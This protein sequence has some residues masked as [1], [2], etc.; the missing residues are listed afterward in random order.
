MSSRV[1][2]WLLLGPVVVG[3]TAGYVGA[4]L[5]PTL[6][7][8]SPLLLI[9]LN[10]RNYHLALVAGEIAFAAFFVVAFLRLVTLD[11]LLFL[12]GR[13][14]GPSGRQ[15]IERQV[16]GSDRIVGWLDRWFPR[17]GWAIVFAAP[18]TVVCLLAGVT[19]MRPLVFAV[20]NVTGT[21]ARILAIW[22]L[23]QQFESQLDS[24]LDFFN[25][26]QTPATIVAVVLVM[27]Q[28][29]ISARRGGGEIGDVVE[30][31]R[32]LEQDL[33]ESGDREATSTADDEMSR[34]ER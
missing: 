4:A 25:R 5:H 26:Y 14:Y 12:V 33:E 3:I 17:I 7:V 16:E 22:W 31:E 19:R 11:P 21:I 13:W 34:D 6:A 29:G 30:L 20:L 18:N 28:I 1:R 8:D 24:V 9:S 32:Q 10:P 2:L 27:I 23:A 15:W